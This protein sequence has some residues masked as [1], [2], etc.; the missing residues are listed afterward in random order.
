MT[1]ESHITSIDYRAT[2]VIRSL[3]CEC[4]VALERYRRSL[5]S[6]CPD[7]RIIPQ[8]VVLASSPWLPICWSRLPQHEISPAQPWSAAESAVL[9]VVQF[10]LQHLG[11]PAAA[12]KPIRPEGSDTEEIL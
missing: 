1:N 3:I 8:S 9:I 12:P 2:I 11:A 4:D 5:S 7:L 6:S 10:P